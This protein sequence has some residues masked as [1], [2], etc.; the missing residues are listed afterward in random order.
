[1]AGVSVWMSAF[2]AADGEG[3]DRAGE[4]GA[5]GGEDRAALGLAD[6]EDLQRLAVGGLELEDEPGMRQSGAAAGIG[7]SYWKNRVVRSC[8]SWVD[9][10]VEPGQVDPPDVGA[11]LGDPADRSAAAG[12]GLRAR[13][14]ERVRPGRRRTRARRLPGGTEITW[15]SW[16]SAEQGLNG[17]GRQ[18][19]D[20]RLTL[21]R[22]VERARLARDRLAD[23]QPAGGWVSPADAEGLSVRPDDLRRDDDV[24]PVQAEEPCRRRP[25]RPRSPRPG[26]SRAGP[27][28]G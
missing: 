24:R 14:N 23:A 9:Q 5:G 4:A 15:L 18:R 21:E 19:E 20:E 25:R 13:A 22:G 12:C 27:A 8:A 26:G 7:P 2:Q 11:G 3:E 6:P 10:V 17:T 1:M 16:N 28:P